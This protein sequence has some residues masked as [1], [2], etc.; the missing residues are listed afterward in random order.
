MGSSS[1]DKVSGDKGSWEEVHA[2]QTKVPK[3]QEAGSLRG[4]EAV[5][6]EPLRCLEATTCSNVLT[7]FT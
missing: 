1:G 7:N 4:G 6:S 3:D 5:K 2:E